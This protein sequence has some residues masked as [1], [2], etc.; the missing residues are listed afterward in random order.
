MLIG[1]TTHLK[2]I[3]LE[4][5]TKTGEEKDKFFHPLGM[6]Y[7]SNYDVNKFREFILSSNKFKVIEKNVKDYNDVDSD[8][9][10]DYS[11][12]SIF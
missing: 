11:I 8:Y 9:I 5:C 7:S 2:T 12:N 1:Q 10:I 3:K 4:S 6:G